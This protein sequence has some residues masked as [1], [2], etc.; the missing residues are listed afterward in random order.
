MGEERVQPSTSE[1]VD[2]AGGD[3]GTRY[4]STAQPVH[5]RDPDRKHQAQGIKRKGQWVEMV[6][7]SD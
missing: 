1:R 3:K 5:R 7:M 2:L 6:K 4:P